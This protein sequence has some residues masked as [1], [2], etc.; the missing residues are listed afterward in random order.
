MLSI[1]A[2]VKYPKKQ[3]LGHRPYIAVGAKAGST[4]FE[5]AEKD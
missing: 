4:D 2:K 5:N 1:S 3:K